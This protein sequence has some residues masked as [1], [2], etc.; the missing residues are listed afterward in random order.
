MAGSVERTPSGSQVFVRPHVADEHDAVHL[1]RRGSSA[2]RGSG[3]WP[4]G[5]GTFVISGPV[6]DEQDGGEHGL[7]AR[8]Q[9]QRFAAQAAR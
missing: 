2:A 5:P 8:P 6:A 3:G 9:S 1:R 4:S 7:A